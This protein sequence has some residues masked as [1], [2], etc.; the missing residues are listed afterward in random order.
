MVYQKLKENKVKDCKRMNIHWAQK[1]NDTP[2]S[3]FMLTG[4]P[5]MRW[6]KTSCRKIY[7]LILEYEGMEK[8]HIREHEV[9][10][11]MNMDK[12]QRFVII[13]SR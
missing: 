11:N 10:D 9:F 4:G 7:Q 12:R 6:P 5:L 13:L 8:V 2:Y 1:L 3:H